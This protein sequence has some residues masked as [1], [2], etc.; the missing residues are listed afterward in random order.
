VTTA[1]RHHRYRPQHFLM[2]PPEHFAVEYVI[3][4]WMDTHTP[5]DRD[6]AVRQWQGLV[7]RYRGLGHTVDELTPEPGL[8]DMV[9]TANGATVVDGH[10]LVAKFSV[11]QREAEEHLHAQWHRDHAA[12]LGWREVADPIWTNEGEGD[13]AA[14]GSMVLAGYGFRT[15]PRAHGELAELTG[16]PVIGLHLVDPWFYHLDTALAVLDDDPDHPD[17]AW[18]PDAFSPGSR[19]IINSLFPEALVVERDDARVL[20]LNMVS[21]GH[22]VLHAAAATGL[23]GP[24]RQRGYEPIPVELDELLKGGGSLKCCTQTL[25]GVRSSSLDLSTGSRQAFAREPGAETHRPSSGVETT[26]V[27]A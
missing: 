7:D 11:S 25:R 15:D 2:C 12:A 19:S 10:V 18:Y 27:R 20:G 22:H 9:Y 3:N 26:G 23:A 13:F 17:I 8:P 5:V 24:L 1:D 14:V 4:P 16:R 21:D 6:R